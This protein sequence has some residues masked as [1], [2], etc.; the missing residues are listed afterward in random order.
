MTETT[1]D[2]NSKNIL[3]SEILSVLFRTLQSSLPWVTSANLHHEIQGLLSTVKILHTSTAVRNPLA[4][5]MINQQNTARPAELSLPVHPQ[6]LY[7]RSVS[8]TLPTNDHNS[9]VSLAYQT[10]SLQG[11]KLPISIPFSFSILVSVK[12]RLIKISILSVHEVLSCSSLCDS[13]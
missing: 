12:H 4:D 3:N 13:Q 2:S 10:R 9:G 6:Q 1:N 7:Q 11:S 8:A 5:T